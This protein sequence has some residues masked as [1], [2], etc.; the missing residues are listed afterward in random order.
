ME[1]VEQSLGMN[2]DILEATHMLNEAAPGGDYNNITTNR[3]MR[4]F[5]KNRNAQLVK[6]MDET[7]T[8]NDKALIAIADAF[9]N[10]IV[11][12]AIDDGEDWTKNELSALIGDAMEVSW[13]VGGIKLVF[14]K[15]TRGAGSTIMKR[16]NEVFIPRLRTLDTKKYEYFVSNVPEIDVKF[17]RGLKD[18]VNTVV[19]SFAEM[20]K[21]ITAKDATLV[22]T[23]PYEQT[24]NV[25]HPLRVRGTNS[26]LAEMFK[27]SLHCHPR[28]NYMDR[29]GLLS[30]EQVAK[31]NKAKPKTA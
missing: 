13:Y 19:I 14:L 29:S 22:D 5:L 18:M 6:H 24:E 3:M 20:L 28:I 16:G 27:R 31:L 7:Y 9:T 21:I 23:V 2:Q 10:F 1:N 25:I 26:V 4:N 17:S 11:N 15:A 8:V 12:V 30:E